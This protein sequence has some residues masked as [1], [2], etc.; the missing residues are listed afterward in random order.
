MA[1]FVRND[2]VERCYVEIS[3]KVVRLL[4]YVSGYLKRLKE[5]R[6]IRNG[7]RLDKEIRHISQPKKVNWSGVQVFRTKAVISHLKASKSF[8]LKSTSVA[9]FSFK[10]MFTIESPK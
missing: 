7:T 3:V 8:N 6:L 5:Q 1:N 4:E 9:S 2:S 10:P